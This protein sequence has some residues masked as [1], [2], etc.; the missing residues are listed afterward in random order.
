MQTNHYIQTL[1]SEF[2]NLL[3]KSDRPQ[4]H[5]SNRLWRQ[6]ADALISCNGELQPF[7]QLT[8]SMGMD[9]ADKNTNET[10]SDYLRLSIAQLNTLSSLPKWKTRKIVI[11]T[12]KTYL[13]INVG[14]CVSSRHIKA[15]KDNYFN[16]IQKLPYPQKSISSQLWAYWTHRLQFYQVSPLKIIETVSNLTSKSHWKI[17]SEEVTD[18]LR[19]NL[20]DINKSGLNSFKMRFVVLSVIKVALDI[21]DEIDEYDNDSILYEVFGPFLKCE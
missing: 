3:T 13:A 14:K 19:L 18:C 2:I 1:E 20:S 9:W 4:N 6:W 5:V 8:V 12:A 11:C 17:S 10:I 21:D 7:D 15:L 16:F